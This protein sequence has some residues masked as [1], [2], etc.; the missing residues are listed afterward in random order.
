MTRSLSCEEDEEQGVQTEQAETK[1][2]VPLL[3]Y[4]KKFQM[5]LLGGTCG[6]FF[7]QQSNNNK[8]ESKVQ[9]SHSK[10]IYTGS[11]LLFT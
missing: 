5:I 11:V 2:I 1:K 3:L 10:K 8:P 6:T 4:F 7:N 9:F